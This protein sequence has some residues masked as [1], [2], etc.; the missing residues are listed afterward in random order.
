MRIAYLVLSA[1]AM[2]GT[3]GIVYVRAEY[4]LAVHRL[5]KAIADAR[6]YD[7]SLPA[8]SPAVDAGDPSHALD[9]DG[10]RADLGAYY[11]HSPTDY[12][13]HPP[14]VVVINCTGCPTEPTQCAAVPT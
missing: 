3:E 10:T 5:E 7:F 12:P 2:G 9:S 1:Y 14:N 6:A 4:P 11:A 13:Y 8:E